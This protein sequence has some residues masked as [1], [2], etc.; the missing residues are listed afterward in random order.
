MEFDDPNM[1]FGLV[2]LLT[3]RDMQAKWSKAKARNI[4]T[5]GKFVKPPVLCTW[6]S[7][8]SLGAKSTGHGWR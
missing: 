4:A 8:G 3:G 6:S 7:I 1:P 5:Q 2:K